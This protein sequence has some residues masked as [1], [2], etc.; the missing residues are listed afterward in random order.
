LAIPTHSLHAAED[1]A[2]K[3]LRPLRTVDEL[4]GL[5][6]NTLL[7]KQ[8]GYFS[9][10]LSAGDAYIEGP[11]FEPVEVFVT[12]GDEEVVVVVVELPLGIEPCESLQEM[13]GQL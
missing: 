12:D 5:P 11:G 13:E 2:H 7:V 6:L 8:R 3:L 9:E 1:L 4:V 10:A